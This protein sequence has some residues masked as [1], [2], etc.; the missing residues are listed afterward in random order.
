MQLTQIPPPVSNEITYYQREGILHPE[1][2]DCADHQ[3]VFN[4][5]DAIL[6]AA[7]AYSSSLSPTNSSLPTT[8]SSS[9]SNATTYASFIKYAL[10]TFFR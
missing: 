1:I 5:T 9:I 3:I 10:Y 8:N 4:L 7:M 2:Y 6:L